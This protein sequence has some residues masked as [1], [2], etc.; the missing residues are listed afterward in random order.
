MFHWTA[1]VRERVTTYSAVLGERRRLI[2][3]LPDLLGGGGAAAIRQSPRPRTFLHHRRRARGTAPS[4]HVLRQ[5]AVTIG[6]CCAD[7]G[8]VRR[9]HVAH[10]AN[11][12]YRL[13]HARRSPSRPPEVTMVLA[14]R[15]YLRF[16]LSYGSGEAVE[17]GM[18]VDHITVCRRHVKADHCAAVPF[19]RSTQCSRRDRPR[20]G[21]PIQRLSWAS[22]EFV[23]DRVQ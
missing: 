6:V 22:V 4:E 7:R 23:D 21:L 13:V 12:C 18:D 1:V 19:K 11:F 8:R 20:V 9:L 10:S 15:R 5:S 3:A 14:V 2:P 16:W 17:R